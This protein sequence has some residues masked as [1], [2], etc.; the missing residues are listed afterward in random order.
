MNCSAI[1]R[2][3]GLSVLLAAL[4]SSA[5]T[6]SV[7]KVQQRYPWN[8]LVDID[9]TVV[10]DDPAEEQDPL[11]DRLEV[12]VTDLSA[13]PPAVRPANSFLQAPLPTSAGRHRIT[14]NAWA[15][16][17]T[18]VVPQFKVTMGLKHC[19]VRYLVVDISAGLT[20]EPYPVTYMSAPPPGGF[21]NDLYRTD[22]LVLRLIP[23][24]SFIM[25]S[26]EGEVR[27]QAA[28]EVQHP[29]RITKPFYMGIFEVTQQQYM[30]VMGGDW[31]SYFKT[32][33]GHEKWPAGTL[34]YTDI[35]GSSEGKKWPQ[36]NSVDAT[37]FCGR[38]R[39]RTG[40]VFDLPTEAQWEY[41]CRAGT[42]TPLNDGEPCATDADLIAHM[43]TLGCF[44]SGNNLTGAAPTIVGSCRPNAWGL[45]DMHGNVSE[46]CRDWF[47]EDLASL[48]QTVDPAG[49]ET[50]TERIT[51]G[52][53][54]GC[55]GDGGTGTVGD[56]RSAARTHRSPASNAGNTVQVGFR[57]S[58]EVP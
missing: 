4:T 27:R 3:A 7:G 42:G 28:K 26:P 9:Y 21:T 38:L 25:G 24:G 10:P 22:R 55:Y 12:S 45:Y 8:G 56:C 14:W 54:A 29:V 15:D 39:A 43:K 36:T 13:D 47:A 44:V 23:P 30:H 51:K 1:V 33:A 32:Q 2:S 35:R 5:V 31:K 20:E 6:V 40:L 50:G 49:P 41:A 37:S 34:R 52:G 58:A 46:F 57:I 19:P 53:S 17:L 48:G 18:G 11:N 16:G